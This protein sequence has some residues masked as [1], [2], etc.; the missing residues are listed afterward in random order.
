VSVTSEARKYPATALNLHTLSPRRKEEDS[1][2]FDA[3]WRRI[4]EIDELYHQA[5][6]RSLRPHTLVAEGLIHS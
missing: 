5:Y 1:S 2:S 3:Q 6:T 4:A